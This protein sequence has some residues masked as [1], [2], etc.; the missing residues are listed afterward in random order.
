MTLDIN[1]MTDI[2]SNFGVSVMM[3]SYF[4]YNSQ[5]TMKEFS[6]TINGNTLVLTRL[7]ERMDKGDLLEGGQGGNE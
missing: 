6:K 4:I 2:L 7:L 1:S 5:T 3:L